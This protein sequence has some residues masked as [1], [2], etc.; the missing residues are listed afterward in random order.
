MTEILISMGVEHDRR[1]PAV[2]IRVSLLSPGDREPQPPQ[3]ITDG[4]GDGPLLPDGSTPPCR[5]DQFFVNVESGVSMSFVQGKPPHDWS[6]VTSI[7]NSGGLCCRQVIPRGER[8]AEAQRQNS[9]SISTPQT[10]RNRAVDLA[11]RIKRAA[12]RIS[13][14][15][16]GASPS[17]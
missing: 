15:S 8:C 3:P 2:S 13:I 4:L 16:V 17:A 7:D 14:S 6:D 10:I 12:I 5:S 11:L 1:S 9:G